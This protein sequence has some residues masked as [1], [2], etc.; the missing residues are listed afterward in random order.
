MPLTLNGISLG[1]TFGTADTPQRGASLSDTLL[2]ADALLRGC[3]CFVAES[4]PPCA[5]ARG[6]LKFIVVFVEILYFYGGV[7]L[8]G[9]LLLAEPSH[10]C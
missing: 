9:N 6:F 7:S 4:P 10:I 3:E 8:S 1:G 5:R 2:M